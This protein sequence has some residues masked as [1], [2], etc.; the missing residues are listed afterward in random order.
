MM[1]QFKKIVEIKLDN[2]FFLEKAQERLVCL[3][4]TSLN[5]VG[6][7]PRWDENFSCEC[8]QVG[9]IAKVG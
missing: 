5:F 6:I 3:R 4:A 9:Q 7:P 8:V 1:Y 2:R